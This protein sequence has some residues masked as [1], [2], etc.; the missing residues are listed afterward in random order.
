MPHDDAAQALYRRCETVARS[1][2]DAELSRAGG[3]VAVGI[4]EMVCS[5]RD[6]RHRGIARA[7]A[8]PPGPALVAGTGMT[9]AA[10]A[11]AIANAFLMHA[12]LADDAYRLAEHPG[13]AVLPVALAA[14]DPG[15]AIPGAAW[16]RAVVGGY[17]AACVLADLLLPDAA[18]RGWRVTALAAPVATAVTACLLAPDGAAVAA[19]AIRIAAATAGGP[20]GVFSGGDAWRLQPA[21]AS[22]QGL[23]A[24]Q[25]AFAGARGAPG[26]LEAPQGLLAVVT[27]RPFAGLPDGAPRI[28]EV[29]FKR[30]PV[31][32][33][34]QAVFDAVHRMAGPF[35]GGAA[36]R[37]RVPPFAAEYADQGSGSVTSVEAIT[38]AALAARPGA[39][40][41]TIE[42]IG[43]P[44]LGLHD[45]VLELS[46]AGCEPVMV[47]GSGDTSA[48]SPDQVAD[49]CAQR[50]GTTGAR[51]AA[52]A[53]LAVAGSLDDLRQAWRDAR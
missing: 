7:L 13:L 46:R 27:G 30:H 49:H 14:A 40:D 8:G 20:L 35:D 15:G 12:Q 38:R 32:M 9:A 19:D 6:P 23:L 5:A 52:A 53:R 44:G 16:L 31:P 48:W 4:T 41:L 51:L 1:A 29:M 18:R 47:T 11:A 26:A 43:D 3:C 37:V 34:G 39:G 25:A 45:A 17:E 42:V 50:A 2:G 28:A 36:L 22:G 24:A 33:Y 10:P 21:L